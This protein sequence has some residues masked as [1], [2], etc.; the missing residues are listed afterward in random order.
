MTDTSLLFLHFCEYSFLSFYYFSIPILFFFLR[1]YL[2]EQLLYAYPLLGTMVAPWGT[3]VQEW[4]A[5][6]CAS[7]PARE[8]NNQGT[9]A[10]PAL[11][12]V[13]LPGDG[14]GQRPGHQPMEIDL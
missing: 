3:A 8:Q 14:E 4:A 10:A 12:S 1:M 11:S 2:L 13:H 9:G 5:R 6:T 7:F